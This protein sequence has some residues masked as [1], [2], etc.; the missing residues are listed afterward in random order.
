M[1]LYHLLQTSP[2]AVMAIGVCL[3]T[4][5]L[6]LR[7]VRVRLSPNRRLLAILGFL[8]VCQGLRIV[9]TQST[10][11]TSIIR[12][13][14]DFVDLIV[15][16]LFLVAVL[17][18]KTCIREYASARMQLRLAESGTSASRVESPSKHPLF[19]ARFRRR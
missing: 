5:W 16:T 12:R 2:F 10:V 4:V 6:C 3:V 17:L 8:A 14:E 13:L 18:F 1:Y 11:M 19:S 9:I 15:A 7:M